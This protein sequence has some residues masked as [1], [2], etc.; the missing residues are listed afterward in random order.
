MTDL[1]YKQDWNE[2]EKTYSNSTLPKITIDLEMLYQ[3]KNLHIKDTTL[4]KGTIMWEHSDNS[5]V[6]WIMNIIMRNSYF[7][8]N[9]V[10]EMI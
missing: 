9:Y 8:F 5:D 6:E 4:L 3:L 2:L 7:N 10:K 1:Y